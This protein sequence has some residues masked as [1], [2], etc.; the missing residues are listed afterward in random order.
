MA[1]RLVCSWLLK[2]LWPLVLFALL[3][4]GAAVG[5]P[6]GSADGKGAL[7]DGIQIETTVTRMDPVLRMPFLVT[8]TV[9]DR[10]RSLISLSLHRPSG[11]SIH[12]HRI[13]IRQDQ[14]TIDGRLTNRRVYRWA[15]SALRPGEVALNFAAMKLRVT[16]AP[17]K[18]WHWTPATRMLKV[19]A[20]PAYLPE[21]LPVT[22]R[23]IVTQVPLPDMRAGQPVDW[24]WT[25]RGLGVTETW[26]RSVLAQQLLGSARLSIGRPE[27]VPVD[28]VD[29]KAP[30]MQ[31]LRVRVP[32]LPDPQAG[33]QSGTDAGQVMLPSVRLPY[34]AVSEPDGAKQASGKL[35]FVTMPARP[36]HWASPETQ[37]TGWH[38]LRPYLPWLAVGAA[39]LWL[40][41]RIGRDLLRR[42]QRRRRHARAQAQ[43]ALADSPETLR[44]LLRLV[45]G[46]NALGEMKRS[47]PNP[48][49]VAALEQLDQACY[50]DPSVVDFGV[51]RDELVRWLP[52]S[53][54]D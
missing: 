13:D 33:D 8:L 2:A 44:T 31:T 49:W 20:L 14:I 32:L 41:W 3:P 29:P 39:V 43:L 9:I 27:I 54:F 12:A 10:S 21:Y 42:I 50:G 46:L 25:V 45:T 24:V 6:V 48:R 28:D 36:L 37:S 52:R 26:L 30:L 53:Y 11:P 22:P 38:A 47:A 15:V 16:G 4:V 19:Q 23:L 18:D 34:V 17:N 35:D 7:P 40:M 1:W 5:A 51:M